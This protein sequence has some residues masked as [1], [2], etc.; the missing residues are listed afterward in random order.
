MDSNEYKKLKAFLDYFAKNYMNAEVVPEEQRPIAV[1][2]SME[3]KS[4]KTAGRALVMA[5]DDCIAAIDSWS[6]QKISEINTD[7]RRHGIISIYEVRLGYSKRLQRTLGRGSIKNLT[8][9]Y[10]IKGLVE[11]M[12]DKSD[13]LSLSRLTQMLGEFENNV[14]R[15]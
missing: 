3:V 9:Y 1:L 15:E 13:S 5:I 12:I 11:D 8:E 4:M 10:Q 6:P 7:L 2:N 14:K